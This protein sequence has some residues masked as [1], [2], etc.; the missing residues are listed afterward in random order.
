MRQAGHF[1][2]VAAVLALIGLLH[3]GVGA[4][5]MPLTFG[6]LVANADTIFLGRAVD[7][8]SYWEENQSGRVILT[9]VVFA[10][11]RVFK[12]PPTIQT[13]LEFLGGT[14]GDTTL[15]VK[16]MPIF[17]RGNRNVLFVRSAVRSVNPIVGVT[18]GRFRVVTDGRGLDTVRAFD[19]SGFSTI[20]QIGQPRA[21]TTAQPMSLQEF[22]LQIARALER[23]QR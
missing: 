17:V 18:F 12:G 3:V 9:R 8:W 21:S 10:V 1:G 16:T 13:S 7:S 5:V 2:M 23:G 4:I 20:A 14:I 6:E 11:D 22:E 15:K 19:G